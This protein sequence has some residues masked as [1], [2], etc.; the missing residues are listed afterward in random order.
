[1]RTERLSN[2]R[3]ALLRVNTGVERRLLY[4]A[5]GDDLGCSLWLF[6]H[7]CDSFYLVDPEMGKGIKYDTLISHLS[8]GMASYMP[9]VRLAVE[10]YEEGLWE[11][12][13]PGRRYHVYDPRTPNIRKRLCLVCAGSTLWLNS[14]T[15]HYNVVLNKDYAGITDSVDSDYPYEEVWGRLNENGIFGETIGAARSGEDYNFAKYRYLGLMPLM[16]VLSDTGERMGFG[17]GLVL[18]QKQNADNTA[19]FLKKTR[20][21]ESVSKMLDDILGAFVIMGDVSPEAIKDDKDYSGLYDLM[22]TQGISNW[23]TLSQDRRFNDWLIG[24]LARQNVRISLDV[25]L[26]MIARF[27][28]STWGS[29]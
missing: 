7:K 19:E 9:G 8:S 21:L 25:L 18:F 23:N 10:N 27:K 6:W 1:M 17:S 12:A 13:L 28:I 15:S 14:T 2:A 22:T 16:K 11:S 20:N 4:L 24:R 3:N 5:A 29:W 26:D